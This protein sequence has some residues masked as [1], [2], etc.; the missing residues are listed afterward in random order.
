V[1]LSVNAI[2][3]TIDDFLKE[4][5][6]RA[7]RSLAGLEP[8]PTSV[9]LCALLGDVTAAETI[10]F[11]R[12]LTTSSR[13]DAV[14]KGRVERLYALLLEL[15][16]RARVAPLDDAIST[17]LRTKTFVSAARTWTLREALSDAWALNTP[18]ARAQLSTDRSAALWDEQPPFARRLDALPDVA[19][20]LGLSSATALVEAMQRRTFEALSPSL[21]EALRQGDDAARDLTAFALKRLDPQLKAGA[22]RQPDLERA[23]AAPWCFEVLRKEDLTHAVT[24][25]LGDLDFHPNAFGKILIDAETP[26]RAPGAHLV[27]LEVPD[28]LRLVLT[29]APGFDGY[30]A[31]LG[32]WGEA[33]VLASTPKTLPFIDRVVGDAAIAKTFRLLFESLLLDEGWLKR[34]V[35]ATSA[36]A[37]EVARLF[38]WRQLVQLRAQA[39][40]VPVVRE[41]L[42][43]GAV[44]ALSDAYV[45]AM[46]RALHVAPERGRYLVDLPVMGESLPTLDA[47]ALEARLVHTLRERFNED[48]WRNPAAGR[49]LTGLAARGTTEDANS[50]AASLAGA[51]AG[52]VSSTASNAQ[53]RSLELTDATRRRV[54]VMG[55]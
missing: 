19:R 13:M 8:A 45:S 5:G 2:L 47:W 28:Q 22:A 10:A 11:V 34:A 6:T 23:L 26:G 44:R 18:E 43:R 15:G 52:L 31:C 14:K 9:D 16:T 3:A 7:H 46:E 49:F 30:A 55:A 1:E 27:K 24:R 21:V 4:S 50:L 39:A 38:A 12:E 17:L 32:A 48:W 53:T 54:L 51:T 41:G 20:Q 37:R 25:T 42:E 40:L 36:Q 33:A 29:A 35:R